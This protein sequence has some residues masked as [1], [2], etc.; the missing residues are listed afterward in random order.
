VRRLLFE[1]HTG[2]AAEMQCIDARGDYVKNENK[3]YCLA[4]L[5]YDEVKKLL[6]R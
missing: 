5:H 2:V 3:T 4:L 1:G 6:I